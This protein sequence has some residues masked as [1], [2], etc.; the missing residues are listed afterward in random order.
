MGSNQELRPMWAPRSVTPVEEDSSM[1]LLASIREASTTDGNNTGRF[2]LPS[3]YV[4]A[5]AMLTCYYSVNDRFVMGNSKLLEDSSSYVDDRNP[6]GFQ[7]PTKIIGI[8]GGKDP[9]CP[10]DTALDL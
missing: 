9:I 7:T 3:D 4:P 1:P 5:Q 10:P 8:Q 6:S 2:R